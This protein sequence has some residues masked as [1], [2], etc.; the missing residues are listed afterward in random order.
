MKNT[1][2]NKSI[3][4]TTVSFISQIIII[5][6]GFISRRVLIY[7]VGV[8][9]L[10]I[11]GLMTNILTVF[12]LAESGIG[13]A[14]GFSLYKPLA[15]NDTEKV[16]S[17]M[18]FFKYTYRCLAVGT[19]IIGLVFYPLLPLFLKGNT[20]SNSNVVYLM[21][22]FSSVVS[23]LWVYKTTL[24][25]SDQNKYLYTIANTATQIVVLIIKICILY[26]TENYILYLSIEIGST[27]IKNI[28][29]T[30]Y[31]DKRYPYLK[32]KTVQRLD[33]ETRISLFKN[34]KALF[35]NKLGYIISQCSDNLV[36][37]SIV[38]VAAVGMY[39]NYLVLI[40]SVSGFVTTFTSGVTASMGNL[41]AKESKE[42]AYEVYKK[43]DFINYW[44]YTFTAIC[45]LC[46]IEPFV[47]IWLGLDFVLS[48]WILILA[49][50]IYYLKG[51]NSSVDVVKNAA[52][53]YY[54]DRFIPII[55][56]ITNMVIS[57]VLARLYGVTGVLAGTLISFVLFSFWTK[58]FFV[59]RDVFKL[60]F[61]KYVV[62]EGRKI[63]TTIIFA[64]IVTYLVS[65]INVINVYIRFGILLLV[66][67]VLSNGLLLI[68][69][70]KTDEFKYI[71][72]LFNTLIIK[73]KPNYKEK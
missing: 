28:I 15:E 38:S 36:I 49:V 57:I 56:A 43:I 21:F 5:L 3:L 66:T 50:I 37:S 61:V 26:Y 23:Y 53:L 8:Q 51:I 54:P 71:T 65:Y 44:L 10:G 40:S 12:S 52:G 60:P 46:L 31:I 34:I 30:S 22:L 67:V 62:W 55:E 1:R 41:V 63:I 24:N 27:I 9:Y 64:V 13:T 59:Y 35:F 32:D 7:S 20:V 45:L 69:F 39:S 18:R 48:K 19:A 11:N 33:Q 17:L 58:P 14:I 4:N 16:K 6:L 72:S 70:Y 73:I 2:T 42:K 68:A 29:F 47:Q 25:S